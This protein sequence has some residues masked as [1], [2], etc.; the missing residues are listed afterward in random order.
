[1]EL[2]RNI[3]PLFILILGTACGEK[4]EN[5]Q[6]LPLA[7]PTDLKAELSDPTTVILTWSDNAQDENGY[8]IYLRKEGDS[9]N[10]EPMATIGADATQYTFSNLT[11]GSE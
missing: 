2:I 9:Y 10:V 1:M 4:S 7:D 6:I 5:E 8:R 11:E 3:L